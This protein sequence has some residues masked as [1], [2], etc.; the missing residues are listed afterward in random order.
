[1]QESTINNIRFFFGQQRYHKGQPA[2]A[3]KGAKPNQTNRTDTPN[4]R[5]KNKPKEQNKRKTTQQKIKHQA[6]GKEASRDKI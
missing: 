2:K 3:Q 5:T 4:Q 6:E 1:M